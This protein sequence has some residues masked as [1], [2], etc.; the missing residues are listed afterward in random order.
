VRRGFDSAD[1]FGYDGNAPRTNR[2]AH[3]IGV[4]LRVDERIRLAELPQPVHVGVRDERLAVPSRPADPAP[5][6]IE[7]LRVESV[8]FDRVE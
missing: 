8:H 2:L 3:G 1:R 6:E 4:R 7:P 5:V